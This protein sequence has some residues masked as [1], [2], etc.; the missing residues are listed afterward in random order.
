MFPQVDPKKVCI[1]C[2]TGNGED[3]RQYVSAGTLGTTVRRSG[4]MTMTSA[5]FHFIDVEL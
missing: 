1:H 3:L 4:V 2:F 5:K